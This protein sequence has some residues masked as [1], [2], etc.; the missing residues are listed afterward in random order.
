MAE[1]QFTYQQFMYDLQLVLNNLSNQVNAAAFT[2]L[3]GEGK[4][5]NYKKRGFKK[6]TIKTA[7]NGAGRKAA[8][9]SQTA[10]KAATRKTPVKKAF[11]K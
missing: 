11:K 10:R 1:R 3:S 5:P 7:T 4:T 6:R 9:A 8:V 2:C